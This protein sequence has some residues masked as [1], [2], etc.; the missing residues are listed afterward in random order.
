MCVA[1][2]CG[3]EW[4]TRARSNKNTTI[5][6]AGCPARVTGLVCRSMYLEGPGFLYK[7]V[8]VRD[9]GLTDAASVFRDAGSLLQEINTGLTASD[10][11]PL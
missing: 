8:K 4:Q 3:T 2:M 11:T 9:D 5:N 6:P 10:F 1:A 7:L